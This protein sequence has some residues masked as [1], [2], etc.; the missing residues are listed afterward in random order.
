MCSEEEESESEEEGD[1]GDSDASS[2]T[3]VA[4]YVYLFINQH[5][6]RSS[7]HFECVLCC[8]VVLFDVY[9]KPL[10]QLLLACA[11]SPT[12]NNHYSNTL[13]TFPTYPNRTNSA[14]LL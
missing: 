4:L 11:Y 10:P 13:S 7:I 1:E 3:Q 12:T 2:A 5:P 9:N 6:P 8:C 14:R